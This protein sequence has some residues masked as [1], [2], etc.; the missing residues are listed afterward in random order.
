MNRH[1]KKRIRIFINVLPKRI[2]ETLYGKEYQSSVPYITVKFNLHI[3]KY[4]NIFYENE[5][6][7]FQVIKIFDSAKL[8]VKKKKKK[9]QLLHALLNLGKS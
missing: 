6:K 9:P 1:K 7:G 2:S 4:L 5:H 8:K 3:K